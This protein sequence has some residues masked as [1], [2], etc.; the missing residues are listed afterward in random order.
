M[1]RQMYHVD[2]AISSN[3]ELAVRVK[4]GDG[5]AAALLLSQNEGYLSS[6]AMKLCG[7]YAL[8]GIVDDLKQEGALALLAAANAYDP[9]GGA[10]LLTYATG[11]VRSAMLDHIAACV[12]PVRL[13]PGRYHQLR[14]V[15]HLCAT[16]PEEFSE[17][18]L[19]EQICTV[20]NISARAARSLL[21]DY[22]SILG[23]VSLDDPAFA[24]SRGGDPARAYDSFMRKK[25][26]IQLMK[27]VLTPRELNVVKYHL[28]LGQPEGQE[29][30]FA[31]LAMRLNY[32]GPSAAEKTFTRAIKKLR[33]SLNAGEYG[34][35]VA[36]GQAIRKAKREAQEWQGSILPQVGWWE[37]QRRQKTDP[38]SKRLCAKSKRQV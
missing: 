7:Q 23:T 19:L 33:N 21:L 38:T 16:V 14:R 13:P 9:S 27:E 5:A 34:V 3:E 36:A 29:M 12:L 30:T 28:G 1:T 6:E 4:S 35:W 10:K 25:L 31:E 20:E 15:A 8:P 26:L 17:A 2:G 37:N 22:R 18:E 11:S 24:V 32:N